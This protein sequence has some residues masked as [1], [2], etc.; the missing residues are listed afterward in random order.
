VRRARRRIAPGRVVAVTGSVGK[1]ST[2]ELIA[3]MAAARG[4]STRSPGTWN[5]ARALAATLRSATPGRGVCVLEVGAKR[6]GWLAR[7][8]KALRPDVVVVTN[9]LGDHVREFGSLDAIAAEKAELV[10]GLAP[11]GTAVLNADDPRVAPMRL[12]CRQRVLTYGR[13][14][15]AD[16]RAVDVRAEWPGRLAF[17]LV[18]DGRDFPV[19]TRLV[20]A[21]HAGVALAALGGALA[22]GV[23]L[24]DAIP[25]LERTE[26][27][28]GRFAVLE[29]G[30]VAFL[31][32]DFKAAI[33]SYA[34]AL[35]LLR[36]ARVP[37]RVAVLGK[38]NHYE[39]DE[40]EAYAAMAERAA[41]AA[42]HVIFTGFTAWRVLGGAAL[43]G[44]GRVRVVE[45]VREA[46]E[47]VRA[48]VGPG[49][50]V[51]L[52]GDFEDD[53]LARVALDFEAPV[54]CWEHACGRMTL[55]DGCERLR[56]AA[57]AAGAAA[58]LL[59]AS[60]P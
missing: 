1:T 57:P 58:G 34:P 54:S 59:P 14:A 6:P 7:A 35:D 23:P 51:L 48:L 11:G 49:D 46:A 36:T 60:G 5:G 50:L 27:L 26:P 29:A 21:H 20:G 47:A 9:V 15:G 53:H 55:C 56:A 4:P 18:H 10:A 40:A 16:L 45:T 22:A 12:R 17:T 31:R 39:G 13:A 41:A 42:D 33:A 24:E 30:G 37:R 25:V 38:I 19:R 44:D 2:K 3:E 32:D 28:P 43:P 8:A 52:K